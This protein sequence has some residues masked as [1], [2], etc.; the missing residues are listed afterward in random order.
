MV[1]P[2]NKQKDVHYNSIFRMNVNSD[3]MLSAYP[4]ISVSDSCVTS[5]SI[6]FN[7]SFRFIFFY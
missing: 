7:I 2:K 1:S 4:I 5:D 3:I 6:S